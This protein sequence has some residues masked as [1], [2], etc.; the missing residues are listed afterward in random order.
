M[1]QLDVSK[2]AVTDTSGLADY[3]VSSQVLDSP[4]DQKETYWDFP[5][6]PENLG[7]YKTIPELKKA[8]DALAIWTVGKGLET[9]GI[10]K[11]QLELINGWGEDSFLSIC[12]NMIVQKKVFGDGFAE[13]IEEGDR[14]VNLKPLY[15]GDMRVIVNKQG[16]IIRYE[17]RVGKNAPRTLMPKNVLHL[18][19]DRIASQIHGTSV[20]EACKWVIDA[21]NEALTDH[22][23]VIHRNRVPVR[24]IE[25]D[26]DNTRKRNALI[27]EYQEAIK[28]GEV[29][30]IP[31]GTVEIKDNTVNIQ[32]PIAW[33][34]YLEN[35][36]YQAVGIPRVIATSENYTEAASKVGY[37]TFEPIYT[38]EQ[39][40][41]EADAYSQLA[42]RFKFNRPPSLMGVMQES[43]AKNTGQLG[44]QP[45][46]VQAGPTRSE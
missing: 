25:V 6:A 44:I 16:I 14:L 42:L 21:R 11:A 31:K 5:N 30:V 33:I 28:K 37:L 23:I 45:N 15:A 2:A 7:Y 17:H 10:T 40:L 36:F 41:L 9:D 20:I 12:E 32:D 1:A 22:R 8:I 26:T 3:S 27:T 34:T 13:I 38:R 35:F 29:L 43:E 4:Q 18:C 46:E 24:I 19:N 39:T